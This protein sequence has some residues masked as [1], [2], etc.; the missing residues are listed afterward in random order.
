MPPSFTELLEQM[1]AHPQNDGLLFD[2]APGKKQNTASMTDYR[3]IVSWLLPGLTVLDL[4]CGD[5]ALLQLLQKEKGIRGVGIE[6]DAQKV[7]TCLAAGLSVFQDTLEAS[8][9]DYPDKQ[10]DY[11]ILNQTLQALE[12]PLHVLKA[13]QRVGKRVVVGFPNFGH[14][15]VRFKLL[16][17]GRMPSSGALPYAWYDTP[18]IHLF[19]I[20]D[21][22]ALCEALGLKRRRFQF[23]LLGSYWSSDE[24]WPGAANWLATHAL[25][26]LE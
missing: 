13:M 3:Q 4:G 2:L 8:L 18:N 9:A 17:S 25:F 15:E 21:F 5:G 6:K 14:W 10:F 16:L 24:P 20:K 22:Q 7:E 26:E 19:T 23:K 11:V 12:N 1:N